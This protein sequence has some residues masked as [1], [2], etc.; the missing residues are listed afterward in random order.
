MTDGKDCKNKEN[1]EA[2]QF[3]HLIVLLLLS[4]GGMALGAWIAPNYFGSDPG[5]FVR[6]IMLRIPSIAQIVI[7]IMTVCFTDY[8]TPQHGLNCLGKD[9]KANATFFS[10]I[11]IAVAIILAFG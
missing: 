8:I 6:Y 3:K 11:A 10:A 9:P 2:V 5:A 1:P 4:I 7:L